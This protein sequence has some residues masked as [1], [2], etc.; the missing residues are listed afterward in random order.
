[1]EFK[2][3]HANPEEIGEY[4]SSLAYTAVPQG[5]AFT[6][7][8]WGMRDADHRIVKTHFDPFAYQ[9][10]NEVRKRWL[11]KLQDT[12]IDCRFIKS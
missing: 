7:A 1:M 9:V 10:G 2:V 3:N 12:K 5:K 6:Y 11:L 4:T 8:V